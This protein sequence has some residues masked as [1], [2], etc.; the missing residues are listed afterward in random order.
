MNLTEVNWAYLAGIL[1]GE[2][3]ITFSHRKSNRSE[4]GF[5]L[6]PI[7]HITGTSK[8]ALKSIAEDYGGRFYSP[9]SKNKKP[10]W[11]QSYMVIWQVTS[12]IHTI[13]SKF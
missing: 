3:C 9:L 6:A 4:Y 1:D 12:E 13:L 7:V 2:G 5:Y 10:K 11:K 8:E